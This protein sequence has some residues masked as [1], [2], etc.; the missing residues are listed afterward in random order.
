MK[1]KLLCQNLCK[2]HLGWEEELDDQSKDIWVSL[3]QELRE[4]EAIKIPHC[5]FEGVHDETVTASLEGCC[6]VFENRTNQQ[7]VPEVLHSKD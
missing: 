3:Q 5:Y 6:G 4:L 1:L 7:S 2:K